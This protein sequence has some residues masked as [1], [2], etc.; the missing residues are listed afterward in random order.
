MSPILVRPVREQL[1][2]DRIIRLLQAKFRRKYDAGSTRAPSRTSRSAPAPRVYPDLVLLSLERGH[3]LQGVVEVETGESVN[4]LEALAQWAHFAQASRGVPP[5]RARRHGRRRAAPVRGQP[6]S[7]R[8]NLELSHR[9]RPGAVHAG[10]SQQGNRRPCRAE[11]AA[12]RTEIPTAEK[13]DRRRPRKASR[14]SPGRR[15]G[16]RSPPRK[17]RSPSPRRGS[18]RRRRSGNNVAFLQVL[19]RQDGATSTS[20]I[21]EPGVP[22]RGKPARQR[23]LFWFRT[24]PQV[25][26]G[27]LPFTD[28]VRRTLEAQNPGVRFDWPRLWRRRF[29]RPTPSTGASAGGWRRRASRRRAK[30]AVRRSRSRG[31]KPRSRRPSRPIARRN[32]ELEPSDEETCRTADALVEARGR[33]RRP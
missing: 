2:H 16:R 21:V 18:Q 4:H 17:R 10:P 12:R 14:K 5:L 13:A 27:R 9:R 22:R 28:D 6:D 33:R 3:R 7:R 26:V 8:R 31:Q 15:P 23:V 20:A 1:E 24:P 11:A 32:E 29:R 25:K 30:R 19:A